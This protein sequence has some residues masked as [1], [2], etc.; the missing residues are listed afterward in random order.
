MAGVFLI[1]SI[2]C[3]E[4]IKMELIVALDAVL[5]PCISITVRWRLQCAKNSDPRC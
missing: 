4:S 3:A 2:S 1:M 5:P